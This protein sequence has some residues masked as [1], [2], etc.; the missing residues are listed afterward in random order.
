MDIDDAL[1]LKVF[2]CLLMFVG[3]YPKI[4]C[5]DLEIRVNNIRELLEKNCYGGPLSTLF[6][7]R[8]LC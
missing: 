2:V 7:T 4:H 6:T 8:A 3:V 5:E 1:T